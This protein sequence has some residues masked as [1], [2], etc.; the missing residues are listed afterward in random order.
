MF[1]FILFSLR[2]FFSLLLFDFHFLDVFC[3]MLLFCSAHQRLPV[4][5]KVGWRRKKRKAKGHSDPE[6]KW[7]RVP[8]GAG[9]SKTAAPRDAA[10]SPT[11]VVNEAFSHDEE[12]A[13]VLTRGTHTFLVHQGK[14]VRL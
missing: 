2:A 14:R 9:A 12:V 1:V 8:N 7:R 13:A 6:P 10:S 5:A 4:T 3:C 11:G